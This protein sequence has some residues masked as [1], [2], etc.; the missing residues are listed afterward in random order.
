MKYLILLLACFI[1]SNCAKNKIE[2]HAITSNH[3]QLGDGYS[4]FQK[5]IYYKQS[6]P[7]YSSNLHFPEKTEMH[8]GTFTNLD[9]RYAKDKTNIYY[10]GEAISNVDLNSFSVIKL[11]SEFPFYEKSILNPK[12]KYQ[13]RQKIQKD[14]VTI[15]PSLIS[16]TSIRWEI[17]HMEYYAKDKN[18]VY[19]GKDTIL[20]ADPNTFK[21]LSILF[22]KD[23]SNVYFK[24]EP[25]SNSDSQSFDIISGFLASDDN[26][27]YYGDKVISQDP[28]LFE[29]LNFN[30]VKDDELVW[31]IR[32][33][34]FPRIEVLYGCSAKDFEIID[35]RYAKDASN[36]F[37][38]GSIIEKAN[39]ENFQVLGQNWSKDDKNIFKVNRLCS[40]IDYDTFEVTDEYVKDKNRSYEKKY[41]P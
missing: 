12:K 19:C 11:E 32:N 21:I 29:I 36:V 13:L 24:G 14:I 22:S 4:A 25:I 26:H 5:E 3:K 9:N 34:V 28:E 23:K 17:T 1:F 16:F 15:S 39:V 18:N 31:F 27:I 40:E 33:L 35:N 2:Y 10:R 6:S 20:N 41:K 38:H 30:Y 7:G 8:F 37:F